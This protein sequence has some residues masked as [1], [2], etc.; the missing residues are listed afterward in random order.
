[1][2]KTKNTSWKLRKSDECSK[3]YAEIW[4]TSSKNLTEPVC[5]IPA[6]DC[7]LDGFVEVQRNANMLLAAP[8]L[9]AACE[10]ARQAAR[11]WM[12]CPACRLDRECVEQTRLDKEAQAMR[13]AA[14]AKAK[15]GV[16]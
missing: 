13:E 12:E 10:K 4:D 15:G 6:D 5:I 8:D 7:T 9:L 1:M 3:S 16:R 2:S 14:I 11:H